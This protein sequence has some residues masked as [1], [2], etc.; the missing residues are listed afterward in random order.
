MHGRS[1]R[2]CRGRSGPRLPVAGGSPLERR[3]GARTGH[4]DRPSRR[5]QQADAKD[6]API[7][8][9]AQ[10]ATDLH[11]CSRYLSINISRLLYFTRLSLATRA[12]VLQKI[13]LPRGTQVIFCAATFPAPLFERGQPLKCGEVSIALGLV[14]IPGALDGGLRGVP[15]SPFFVV[16][17][18]GRTP[19]GL[20][21]TGPFRK[22]PVR[23]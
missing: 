4:V 22:R 3:T 23:P 17:P 16:R 5:R 21:Q 19:H 10:S 9:S 6:P 11:V 8:G 13:G 12:A 20:S 15:R 1:A 14:Q 2:T 7:A 18:A